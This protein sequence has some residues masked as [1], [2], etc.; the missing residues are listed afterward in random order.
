MARKILRGKAMLVLE[1]EAAV[2]ARALDIG[3]TG[4]S[5]SVANMVKAGS[6]GQ[7]TFEM[8]FDGKSHIISCKTSVTYCIFSGNEFKVGLQ[9][10]QMDP[11]SSAVINRYMR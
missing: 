1:G 4:M 6:G 10:L 5:V 2:S 7:L 9:F 11:A 3:N 8:Y